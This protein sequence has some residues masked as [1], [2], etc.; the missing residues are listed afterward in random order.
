MYI[1]TKILEAMALQDSNIGIWD[2][3][4]PLEEI[5]LRWCSSEVLLRDI[6]FLQGTVRNRTESMPSNGL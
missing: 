3:D 2:H 6:N 1:L 4:K 5:F